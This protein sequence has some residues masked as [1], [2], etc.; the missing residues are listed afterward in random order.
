MG[1]S[2]LTRTGFT[3]GAIAA[4]FACAEPTSNPSN[5]RGSLTPSLGV[6]LPTGGTANTAEA[7]RIEVCKNYV[8]TSRRH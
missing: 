1:P 7:E 5:L 4:M 3:V 8:M 2:R 6:F